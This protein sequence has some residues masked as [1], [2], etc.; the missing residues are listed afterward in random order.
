MKYLASFL[1]LVLVNTCSKKDTEKVVSLEGDWT[2]ISYQASRNFEE[3]DAGEVILSFDISE[4]ILSVE[5]NY[6][7]KRLHIPVEGRYAFSQKSGQINIEDDTFM[8]GT[9][10][11]DFEVD[12][13]NLILKDKPELDGP[14]MILTKI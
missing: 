4:Q 14:L 1:I 10:T 13:K 3:F 12:D 5:N 6:T 9:N 7:E 11:L 2:L 8:N